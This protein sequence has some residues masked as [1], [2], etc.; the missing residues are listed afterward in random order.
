MRVIS[1]IKR[2]TGHPLNRGRQVSALYQ[3]LKWQVGS[4]LF[5]EQVIYN[6][7]NGSRFIIRP[8]ERGY[9]GIIYSGLNE[10]SDMAYVLHTMTEADLFVD[11]GANIGAYTIL[12]CAAKGARG[13]C[14][15][16]VPSTYQ[17]L[18]DNLRLNGLSDRVRAYNLGLA[19]KEGE[20]TFTSGENILNH[21]VANGEHTANAVKVPVTTLDKL[22]VDDSPTLFKIDVEGF[23][24]PVIAGAGETL[25]KPS[26]HSV[27]MELNGMGARYGY[28]EEAIV[29]TMSSHGFKTYTYEPFSRQLTSLDGQLNATENTLFIRD[30]EAA[31]E[32]VAK[33]PKVMIGKVWL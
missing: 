17:R 32:R 20:L 15:E 16:P 9:N 25:K 29:E 19:D 21:V 22:L 12:A 7:V 26:L 4:R 33:A 2:I 8:G 28:S 6:W 11:I 5:P 27:I 31:R 14:F 23:E 3:F 10:F 24:T 1:A 30:I 13:C 18:Q